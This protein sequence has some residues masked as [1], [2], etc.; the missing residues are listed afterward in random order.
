MNL[1]INI[2]NFS[3]ILKGICLKTIVMSV[4][5][6]SSTDSLRAQDCN[7]IMACNDLVHVSLGDNCTET[8]MPDMILEGQIYPNDFYNVE[9]KTAN[10]TIITNSIMTKSHIGKT[11]QVIVTLDGCDLSCWGNIKIED[12]L[13]PVITNCPDVTVDCGEPTAPNNV[14]RPSAADACTTIT[15]VNSDK[16]VIS[17]CSDEFVKVITRTWTASDIYGNKSTCVQTIN[18]TRP[19][20]AD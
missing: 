1:A 6:F 8:I 10:G 4:L 11:Y 20:I 3:S 12:K 13:P 14:P 16:E 17:Q 7:I 2:Q 15:L 18:V 5:Y 9:V 19:T